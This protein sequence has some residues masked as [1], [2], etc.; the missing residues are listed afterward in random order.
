MQG[1]SMRSAVRCRRGTSLVEA[2]ATLAVLSVGLLGVL[3][4]NILASRQ[5]GLARRQAVATRL[6]RDMVDA[7]ERLPYGHPLLAESSLEPDSPRFSD[8]EEPEGLVRL[9]DALNAAPGLRPL[10]GASQALLR[11]EV[12]GRNS[13]WQVAWRV[14]PVRGEGGVTEARRILVTV[15]YLPP[16]SLPH[17]VQLWVIKPNPAAMGRALA[18]IP[19]I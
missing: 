7:L 12:Q 2:M 4:V 13:P 15:Q 9:E 17:R 8:L 16:G 19:E 18:Y 5:T 11:G 3:Q 14:A 6:A 10:L 1:N